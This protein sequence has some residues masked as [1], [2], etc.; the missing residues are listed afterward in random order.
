MRNGMN[1]LAV[2]L[3]VSAAVAAEQVPLRVDFPEGADA[4]AVPVSGG[5]PFPQGRLKDLASVRLTGAG[6]REIPCQVTRLAVWPD[7][8]IKW[9]LID[10][11][12]PTQQGS[13]L[14]LE[15]G[16]GIQRAAIEGGLD[17]KL[18][19]G[20]AQ[21]SGGGVAASIRKDGS[22]A[23]DELS[24]NGKAVLAPGKPAALR[25]ET[26]RIAD[27]S[28][29]QALPVMRHLL[30][31][32]KHETGKVQVESIALEVAG[33]IRATVLVRGFVLLPSFGATLPDEVKQK[34]PAG[35][36]PFS[37][38]L[39][40]Y[41][42]LPLVHGSHQII[43]SGEPDC[44]F[45]A[46]W[47]V[48]IPGRAG[49]ESLWV[50]DHGAEVRESDG[51]A[52]VVPQP[53][54]LCSAPLDAGFALIRQ[55]WYHRPCAITQENGSAW[56]EFWPQAAGVWDLRR[57]AREWAV[58]ESGDPRNSKEIEFFARYAAR[59]MAKSHDFVLDFAS[60]GQGAV[61][62]QAGRA[63]LVAPPGWYANTLALG[64]LA[65]EQTTGDFAPLDAAIRR[66]IDYYLFSQD[67]F[68]WHGKLN[69][70]FW[71]S[72][73][74]EIHRN[75]RWDNDYG[76]WGWALND[77]AGR[78]G[79]VAMQQ[80]LRTLERRY[81]DAGE[82]FARINYD[83]NM[84]HTVQ[85][86]EN[87]RNWWTATGSSH[88]HNV[89][90]FGCPYVGMRGSNPGAQRILH[91]LTGDGVI[92]DG[93]ELVADASFRY[94]NGEGSRLCNSG[95]SDGQG[96]ASNALLWKFETTGEKKYLD[97]CRAVLDKSG[98]IPPKDGK[99]LG[100]GPSFG[101]FNAA[102]EYAEVSG[103][104]VFRERVVAVAKLGLKQKDPSSFAYAIAM[105]ARFSQDDELKN[106]LNE[107]LKKAGAD[108]KNSL[109]ELPPAQWPG[110]AGYR[111]ANA[112]GN[113]YRDV[114]AGIAVLSGPVK[115]EWP[116]LTP[117]PRPLP[118][119]APA[120]WYRPGGE[121]TANEKV[122]A[123]KDLLAFKPAGK[124]GAFTA[125]GVVWTA[126]KSLCDAVEVNGT[127][128]LA[129]A[130]VPYVLLAGEVAHGVARAGK[131]ELVKGEVTALGAAPD[132]TLLA[133]AKA[134]SAV[135]AL[136]LKAVDAGV[137]VEAAMQ[138]AP[139]AGRIASWGLLVPCKLGSNGHAIHV[140][141][142]GRFRLERLRLDQNDEKVPNWLSAMEGRENTPH[143]PK[144][145][146]AGIQAGPGL[147]YS[148]WRASRLD[149]A[150]VCCE[151][152]EG[153]GAWLDLSDRGGPKPWGVTARVLRSG[154]PAADLSRQALRVNLE[155]GELLVQFHDE[156]APPVSET[157]A[158]AGL[159][160]ACDLIFH[161]GWRPPLSKPELT[162]AQY[163]KF[164]DAANVGEQYGLNALRYCLSDT[165]KVKGREWMEKIRDL[166]IEPR[167]LLYGMQSGD[168]LNAI[169][170]K[171]GVAHDVADLEGTVRRVIEALKK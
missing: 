78:N 42:G 114:P 34:E 28:S 57:Y 49:R 140:T 149:V 147:H 2:A 79:Q 32:G 38:R 126:E 135:F 153:P 165:H 9:A 152:G 103:D 107:L 150:P 14:M 138:L 120:D 113:M 171:L 31:G 119:T 47:A 52:K 10:A 43:F 39:T 100:Y 37:M 124:G 154:D 5:I 112:G 163:E 111:T 155:T 167:E 170:Q 27:G 17:A 1:W 45:I 21:L 134:G 87:S 125:G 105:G 61:K 169:C 74:G 127:K 59:G 53:T 91:L 132:G 63:L 122:P 75:D 73:Y 50:L 168:A 11:I 41:K 68:R 128:P 90:P 48:E 15:F 86:L 71:Q 18:V 12:L 130:I 40:F 33:P 88:R 151:S 110:H 72:R 66:R 143:W 3:L 115:V 76:R 44:D 92:A 82:A 146:H 164:I 144:W 133:S 25:I 62:A 85:H 129:G 65:P 139:G 104:P 96:T 108:A 95:G 166:N 93:L 94:V 23:V 7:G 161:D 131:L 84:V 121:Q 77:G 35:R 98:L 67:L 54:R 36:M 58:G 4:P 118:A 60:A 19:D 29:G 116:K 56:I 159:P 24:F 13:G 46:R 26:L 106:A 80:F 97:A 117:N 157:A 123:A 51:A 109:A 81:F 30:A 156:A 64:P 16:P 55:G 69:Y 158:A 136:R 148:I 162:P 20:S 83:T 141:A 160:G 137:R 70:G 145:R 8:S 101:L 99:G 89:Q 6:G 102:G 22:G 142:P